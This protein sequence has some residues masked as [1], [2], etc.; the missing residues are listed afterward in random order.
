MLPVLLP[1]LANFQPETSDDPNAP[2][3]TPLNR[4]KEWVTATLDL[5]DGGGAKKYTRETN[6]MPNWAG[7]CWYYLRYLDPADSKSFCAPE[8][9][10]YWMGSNVGGVDL[11][12][13]GVEHAVLHLLYARFWHKVL[14]D[15]GHVSTIEPFQKL[16]NQGYV[17]AAAYTDRRGVYVPAEEVTEGEEVSVEIDDLELTSGSV[18]PIKRSTIFFYKGE[19]VFREYGKMGK[20]LK[21]AVSPDEIF[22]EYGCDTMRLYEMAMGP[23]EASK[24]WNTRDIAGPYRFLQKVWRAA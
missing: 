2:V 1:E 22:E 12:V 5:G 15:L 18:E 14:F 9:E 4:A 7:S 24:P 8:V 21:N 3:R 17:L 16:F 6:T 20:S 13:G 10:K 11:Y 23:L 19:P